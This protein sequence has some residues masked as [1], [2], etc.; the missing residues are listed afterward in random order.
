M[1]RTVLRGNEVDV[2]VTEGFAGGG[3]FADANRR[4]AL[5]VG[6]CVDEVVVGDVG[7]EVADVERRRSGGDRR[8]NRHG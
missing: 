6:E 8:R 4:E 3:V 5:E 2:T 1:K 7:V